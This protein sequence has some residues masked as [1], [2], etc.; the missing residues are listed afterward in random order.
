LTPTT[1]TDD[2]TVA[3]GDTVE[4]W[5]WWNSASG[6]VYDFTLG[7]TFNENQFITLVE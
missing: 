6:F 3:A 5:G 2:I 4:L 1:Y 7:N